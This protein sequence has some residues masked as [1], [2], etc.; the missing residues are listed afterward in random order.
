MSVSLTRRIRRI[1]LL[2]STKDKNGNTVHQYDPTF[3]LEAV[4]E[5][6]TTMRKEAKMRRMFLFKK[7]S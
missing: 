4:Q 5:I 7:K 6:A 2:P 3:N 1:G